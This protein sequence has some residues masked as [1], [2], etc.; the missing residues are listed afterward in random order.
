MTFLYNYY[1]ALIM[2]FIDVLPSTSV[3]PSFDDSSIDD[4]DKFIDLKA[5]LEF[6]E[7]SS[8]SSDVSENMKFQGTHFNNADNEFDTSEDDNDRAFLPDLQHR[9]KDSVTETFR[10][11]NFV[12]HLTFSDINQLSRNLL[13]NIMPSSSSASVTQ[14]RKAPKQYNTDEEFEFVNESDVN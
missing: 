3:L 7:S 4:V 13:T 5:N 14:T 1:P 2:L 12:S 9:R 6:S 10:L 8:I 11:T